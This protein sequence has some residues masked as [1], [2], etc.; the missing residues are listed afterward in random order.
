ML[1]GNNPIKGIVEKNFSMCRETP[2]FQRLARRRSIARTYCRAARA[3][4]LLGEGARVSRR[5]VG[6]AGSSAN[7]VA[8]GEAVVSSLGIVPPVDKSGRTKDAD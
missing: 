1:I 5:S 4:A 7:F 8:T 3:I 2:A 6:T